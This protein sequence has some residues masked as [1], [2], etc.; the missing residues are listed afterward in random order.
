MA[1]PICT[2][3]AFQGG[4]ALGAYECGVV[5]ELYRAR[6]GP[7]RFKPI[8]VTGLSSGA[9]NAAILAG[10]RTADPVATLDRVW[11]EDF[12]L[13][14]PLPPPIRELSAFVP[15]IVEQQLSALGNAGM[16][17]VRDEYILLPFFAPYITDSLY[18]IAPLRRTL[19]REIDLARLNGAG[20]GTQVIVTAVNVVSGKLARFGNAACARAGVPIANQG[21]MS[22]D[23]VLASASL[24]PGFPMTKVDGEPFWDGGIMSN[25]PLSEAINCLEK[26]DEGPDGV[27]RELIF[28]ELFPLESALPTNLQDVVSRF[29]NLLFSSKIELDKKLFHT[30]NS[31][32]DFAGDVQDVLDAIE[33]RPALKQQLDL[34]LA[35]GGSTVR[36][37]SLRGHAGLA[38][39]LKHKKI[40]AFTYIPFTAGAKLATPADFS[41][42]T[43]AARIE[44][45]IQEARRQ[46]LEEPHVLT[47]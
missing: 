22:L 38:Q 41:R 17:R 29:F 1:K 46:N 8:A 2:A 37:D 3:I 26:V 15:P 16:Y 9:V 31:L 40:D 45:G 21:D 18:D 25:L 12:S 36:V 47:T 24:P 34:A 43:I 20:S 11:R 27:V 7:G 42:A 28:V 44:A 39:L 33:V 32:I 10:A 35:T 23:H 13:L 30:F 4:G 19:E 14:A 5:E 6:G